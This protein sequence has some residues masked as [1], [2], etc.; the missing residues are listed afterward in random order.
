[1]SRRLRDPRLG[2]LGENVYVS[3]WRVEK[4]DPSAAVSDVVRPI[5]Y[6]IDASV[7][8][9]WVPWI[10]RGIEAWNPVFESIGF[11]HAIVVHDGGA[12]DQLADGTDAPECVVVW[13]TDGS[14]G[15]TELDGLDDDTGEIVHCTIILGNSTI[16]FLRSTAFVYAGATGLHPRYPY[17]DSI[18]G[19]FLQVIVEH[20]TGHSLGLDHNHKAGSTYPTDSLRK[21]TFVHRMGCT[22]SVMSYVHFDTVEQ[23]GDAIAP[24]DLIMRIGP[25][26]VFALGWAYRPIPE[27]K[28]PEAEQPTL[29]RWLSA[30]DTAPYLHTSLPAFADHVDPGDRTTEDMK[31]VLGDN[32]VMSARY[33]INN[34]ARIAPTIGAQ[35]DTTG[36]ERDTAALGAS[37][38]NELLEFWGRVL[39]SAIDVVGGAVPKGPYDRTLAKIQATPVDSARQVEALRFAIA[40]VFYGRDTLIETLFRHPST[41]TA[42]ML[43]DTPSAG[44]TTAQWRDAQRMLA[45]RLFERVERVAAQSTTTHVLPIV[46]TEVETLSRVLGKTTAAKDHVEALQVMVQPLLD[47]AR[48]VC[49]PGNTTGAA[50]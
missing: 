9:Q 47:P 44:W 23:P 20:E 37:L 19:R 33:I 17:P 2:Y 12:P 49:R 11:R 22:P 30:Q 35:Y 1:M 21:A 18:S 8:R 15:R 28:T 5:V 4:K 10:T 46:C 26:D 34:L 14:P 3:R 36:L 48:G 29:E 25:Y 6:R 27:A 42:V 39:A 41:D 43:F 50:H 16:T 40:H 24:D 32:P 7:P 45:S 38:R 31:Y 13:G